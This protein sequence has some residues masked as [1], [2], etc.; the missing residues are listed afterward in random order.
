MYRVNLWKAKAYYNIGE[1]LT[2]LTQVDE[3][4]E[5]FKASYPKLIRE[6]ALPQIAEAEGATVTEIKDD[7]EALKITEVEVPE[8]VTYMYLKY[9]LL[10][11]RLNKSIGFANKAQDICTDIVMYLRQFKEMTPQKC[12]LTA[13]KA[14]EIQAILLCNAREY[15]DAIKLLEHTGLNFTKLVCDHFFGKSEDDDK[16]LADNQYSFSYRKMVAQYHIN[17]YDYVNAEK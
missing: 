9:R 13:V 5:K 1:Y 7:D 16:V 14:A 3:A 2:S 6:P 11:A 12:W 8:A 4:V 17:F 15:D 10:Q